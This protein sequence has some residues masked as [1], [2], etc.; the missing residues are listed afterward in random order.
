MEPLRNS[1]PQGN[2]VSRLRS[3]GQA[4]ASPIPRAVKAAAARR[5]A[6]GRSSA[7][8]RTPG[9]ASRTASREAAFP[10][11]ARIGA[12]IGSGRRSRSSRNRA[13]IPSRGSA[14]EA[15]SRFRAGAPCSGPREA[16]KPVGAMAGR[17]SRRPPR[18]RG[19]RGGCGQRRRG[20]ADR[21]KRDRLRRRRRRRARRGREAGS[22]GRG[23]RSL[24]PRFGSTKERTRW[25]FR[26]SAGA[27]KRSPCPS[28]GPA[29]RSRRAVRQVG[30]E[31][32]NEPGTVGGGRYAGTQTVPA[33]RSRRIRELPPWMTME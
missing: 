4:P 16:A 22:I 7:R 10:T 24:R 32:R 1:V 11:A 19:V 27:R 33:R 20:A 6:K 5:R 17:G 21:A 29:E 14:S 8:S 13:S 28:P 25:R 26:V 30:A 2:G 9:R 31:C 15:S 3:T 18:M 23:Q 12:T